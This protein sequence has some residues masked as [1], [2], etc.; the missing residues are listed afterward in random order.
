MKAIQNISGGEPDRNVLSIV[1]RC[2]SDVDLE[3][4]PVR[5]ENEFDIGLEN[6]YQRVMVLEPIRGARYKLPRAHE[7]RCWGRRQSMNVDAV[8]DPVGHSSA[9]RI[10]LGH[11]GSFAPEST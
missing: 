9:F 2:R 10:N 8:V 3:L 11:F 1:C 4:V 6:R 5:V 7:H